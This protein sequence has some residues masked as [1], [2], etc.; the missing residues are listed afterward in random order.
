MNET[1]Y[2]FEIEYEHSPVKV[3]EVELAGKCLYV[4]TFND[5]SRFFLTR[6]LDRDGAFFWTSV[7]EG[8]QKLAM[9]I[10]KLIENHFKN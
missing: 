3:E 7:P 4:V 6:A 9:E 1:A 10:G 2:R 5:H 8:K